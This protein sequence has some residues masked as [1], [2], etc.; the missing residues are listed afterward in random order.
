[1]SGPTTVTTKGA[2]M[3]SHTFR[4][5]ASQVELRVLD[6]LPHA[7][8]CLERAELV[9]R[10]VERH[11]SR[12]DAT[13]ALSRANAAPDAWHLVPDVVADAVL[14]AERAHR[15]TDGLFDPRVLDALLA[16]GYDRSLPFADGDVTTSA[17]ASGAPLV[18]P[19]RPTV[20]PGR[21]PG[22]HLG[23]RPVDLGG[24]GKG[25]A[26]RRAAAELAGAGASWLV[27]AGGD[28]YLGGGGPTGSGWRV[29]VEDPLGGDSPV[30]VLAVRD[31][32]CA[33]SST[34][35]RRWTAA[36]A[37]VH[38]LVDPRSGRPGGAGL[39][40]VTVV[41]PDA[42]WAEVWTKALFLTGADVIAAEA[43]AR[44]LAAAWVTTDGLVGT[45]PAMD[46]LVVWRRDRG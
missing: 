38:H 31:A 22:L 1:M 12:F 5:M 44:L 18:E 23:G 20:R 3:L 13:S 37:P 11:C 29:G 45:S 8:A 36:G 35:L 30:L 24:I 46:P 7:A 14:E 28:E 26:V 17:T 33:T 43:D 15:E 42:A 19:W 9:V 40:A 41:G 6:P 32:G 10:E 16:W 21:R 4:A 34:R 2:M 25:L 27:D 39:A